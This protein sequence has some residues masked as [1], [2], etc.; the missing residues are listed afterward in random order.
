MQS[1]ILTEEDKEVAR[2]IQGDIPVDNHPFQVI[3]DAVGLSEEKVIATVNRLKQQGVIRKF[4]AIVRHQR[5]GYEKNAM[6][7][8]AVPAASCDVTGKIFASCK[9]I[10]HCYERTPPFEGRYNLFTMIHFRNDK[11]DDLIQRLADLS[12]IR[13]YKILLS[14]EEFKKSSMVYF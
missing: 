10:T 7:V 4:S 5:V 13:D 3:G 6:V 9:E 8:W 14:I 11:P 2:H 1:S 12:E